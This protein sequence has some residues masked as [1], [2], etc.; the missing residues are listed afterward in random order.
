VNVIDGIE[1]KKQFRF[2]KFLSIL[3][4]L[5]FKVYYGGLFYYLKKR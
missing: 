2:Q 3:Y 5:P 4:I 1:W